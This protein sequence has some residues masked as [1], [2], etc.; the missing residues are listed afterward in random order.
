MGL[1]TKLFSIGGTMGGQFYES[2]DDKDYRHVSLNAHFASKI[3]IVEDQPADSF[4]TVRVIVKVK[5]DEGRP[6]TV[7]FTAYTRD[8]ALKVGRF[9][10]YKSY[11]RRG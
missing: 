2:Q 7:E 3:S 9:K 6:V 1:F 11:L 10:S 8:L 4:K 5:D